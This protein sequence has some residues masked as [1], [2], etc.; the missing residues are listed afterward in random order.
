M[1]QI[2]RAGA[3]LALAA[4]SA[5]ACNRNQA[6]AAPPAPPPTPV[7]ISTARETPVDYATEY[8]ATMKSLRSTAIQPRN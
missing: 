1:L 7:A 3:V 2:P 6:A 5:L 4:L 8:V